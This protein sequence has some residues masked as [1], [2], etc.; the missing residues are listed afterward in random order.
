MVGYYSFI[1]NFNFINLNLLYTPSLE[2]VPQINV[3]DNR[4]EINQTTY[5]PI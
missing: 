1:L 3:P 5:L 2:V 4:I